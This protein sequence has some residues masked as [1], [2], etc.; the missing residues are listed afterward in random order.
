MASPLMLAVG[1]AGNQIGA[2]VARYAGPFMGAGR[3]EAPPDAAFARRKRS[4][5]SGCVFVDSEPKVRQG[6]AG[7][8]AC[9]TIGCISSYGTTASRCR[10]SSRWWT[11]SRPPLSRL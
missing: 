11:T 1:Q 9:G 2:A 8:A 10:S 7:C 3:D 5:R 6:M 4:K